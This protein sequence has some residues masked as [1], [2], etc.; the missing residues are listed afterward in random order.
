MLIS[1]KNSKVKRNTLMVLDPVGVAFPNSEQVPF[2]ANYGSKT[3]YYKTSNASE[4]KV[5]GSNIKKY[6]RVDALKVNMSI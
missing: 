3:R 5:F 4:H 1:G 2:M 6:P